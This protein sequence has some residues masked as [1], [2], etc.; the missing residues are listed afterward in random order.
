LADSTLEIPKIMLSEQE[1]HR[2]YDG[3]AVKDMSFDDF[4]KEVNKLTNPASAA[5]ELANMRKSVKIK[6]KN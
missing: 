6:G 2:I 1:V 5:T 4:R 3:F